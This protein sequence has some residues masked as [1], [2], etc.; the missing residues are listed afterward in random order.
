LL[1]I[2]EDGELLF[3][4]NSFSMIRVIAICISAFCFSMAQSQL[5]NNGSSAVG[6]TVFITLQNPAT[7]QRL[8][9]WQDDGIIGSWSLVLQAFDENNNGKPDDAERKKG[10]IGKHFYQFNTD[11]TC[12]IHTLKLK[13]H[14]ELKNEG[15]KKRLY[16]YID[17]E[18]SKTP[19][20]KWYV[21][22][23]SETELILLSQDKYAFWIYKR[24]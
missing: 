7:D 2:V 5:V 1:K 20:N 18:G 21:I 24:V 19:E 10:T 13:G 17:D 14:Y 4:I 22:S 23:V 16:T 6:G 8:Y 9:S 11:G 15:G 12:L 3:N